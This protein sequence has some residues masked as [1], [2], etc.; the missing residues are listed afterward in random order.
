MHT[1]FVADPARLLTEYPLL[2]LLATLLYSFAHILPFSLLRCYI[3]RNWLRCSARRIALGAF[4]IYLLEVSCQ[5]WL[6][7]IYSTRIGLLFH[8]IYLYYF[9]RVTAIPF[10][11]QFSL[12]LPLGPLLLLLQ[13]CAFTM[14]LQL[15]LFPVPYLTAG[16][17]DILFAAALLRPIEWMREHFIEPLLQG[18]SLEKSWRIVFVLS[19]TLLL[20]S[21]M[22]NPFNEDR[23]L[24]ALLLRGVSLAGAVLCFAILSFSLQQ[25]MR[26][27]QLNARLAI[28]RELHEIE[29]QH[30]AGMTVAASH[31]EEIRRELEQCAAHIHTLLAQKD[32]SGIHAYVES[33]LSSEYLLN[34][35]HVCNNELVNAIVNYWLGS[36]E[37]LAVRLDIDIHLSAAPLIDPVHLTAI[38]GN[39]LKN[40]TEA[41][42]RIPTGHHREL[43]LHM[44]VIGSLLVITMDNTFTGTLHQDDDLQYL[45]A[46]RGFHSHG[47]GLDSIRHSVEACHGTLQIQ[48]IDHFFRVSI[49]LPLETGAVTA[50]PLRS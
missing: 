11:K 36:L 30:Y 9:Y 2:C 12:I 44:A 41:L 47:I 40:A 46:K 13:S 35:Q 28:T 3:F 43:S 42:Q 25:V 8:L 29:S 33:F 1:F 26:Q 5:L 16:L 37:T 31:S 19:T 21:L 45:S 32:Y 39:L 14:E 6:G 20:L 50:T 48:A 22:V 17:L 4:G 18:D 10:F 23:S 24:T 49:L 15:Q 34:T 38:L 7:H 27:R